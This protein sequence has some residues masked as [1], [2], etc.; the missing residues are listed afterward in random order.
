MQVILTATDGPHRGRVYV[1]GGHDTFI[2][3]RAKCVHFRLPEKDM[4]FFRVHFMV[5][6]NP[7]QCRLVD[8]GS[9]NGTM[10]NG[11]SVSTVNLK[12]GDMIRGG[13][14]VMRVSILPLELDQ[15]NHHSAVQ[16]LSDL[17]TADP[18]VSPVAKSTVPFPPC[19]TIGNRFSGNGANQYRATACRICAAS[20]VT[21]NSTSSSHGKASVHSFVCDNCRREIESRPQPVPGYD[22]VRELGR[23]VWAWLISRCDPAM[24]NWLRSRESFQQSPR[25]D[26]TWKNS[27]ARPGFSGS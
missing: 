1:F 17:P 27:F 18:A 3:G 4:F 26:G 19:Q 12:D 6:V 23:G 7:S 15:E 14:S 11:K 8:L 16:R 13:N 5:E 9:R 24:V 25:L 22:I 20:V 21:A 10:V 2:V